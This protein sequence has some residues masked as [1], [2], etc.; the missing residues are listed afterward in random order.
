MN[1]N[2]DVPELDHDAMMLREFGHKLS[3]D[4]RLERRAIAALCAHMSEH[5][6]SPVEVYDGDD[7]TA[8]T[9]TKSAMELIFNLDDCFL[10][11]RKGKQKCWVRIILGNAWHEVVSDYNC[12][13]ADPGGFAAAVDAFNAE[14]YV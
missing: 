4:G 5:D 11:F 7:H 1:K 12:P 6:W 10:Y 13:V 9:D 14:E 8:V 3:P 2:V